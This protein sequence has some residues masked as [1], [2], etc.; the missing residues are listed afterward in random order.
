MGPVK[1]SSLAQQGLKG[2]SE[3]DDGSDP[4]VYFA[5]ERTLLAWLRTGI[6]VIGLGFL[7]ARFGLFLNM[8]R[9]QMIAGNQ[10]VPTLL[11]TG[12]VLLG[13]MMIA[14]ATWQHLQF[15]KTLSQRE[16]PSNYSMKMSLIVAASVST[17]GLIMAI[18]LT[19]ST[20]AAS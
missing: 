4:R 13:T 6:A 17:S 16:L 10:L 19:A 15:T 3:M 8:A 1:A 9:G 18:Y 12:F 20:F 11:G 2:K 5:A 14:A 7:I